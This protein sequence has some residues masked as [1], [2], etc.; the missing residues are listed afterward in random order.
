MLLTAI[1]NLG[2]YYYNI[3]ILWTG[4]LPYAS[5]RS[6]S[7]SKLFY[8]DGGGELKEGWEGGELGVEN[9]RGGGG[10]GWNLLS[11]SCLLSLVHKITNVPVHPYVPPHINTTV[12]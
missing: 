10:G 2:L 3:I 11:L 8:K 6:L 9:K 7:I 5:Y 12:H 4:E 1:R